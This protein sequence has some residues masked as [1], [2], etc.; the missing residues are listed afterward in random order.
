MNKYHIESIM[1]DCKLSD[2]PTLKIMRYSLKLDIARLRNNL[3]F[4]EKY[5]ELVE[6]E[7]ENRI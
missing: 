4:N 6:E 1:R 2:I 7:L 3:E 5:I